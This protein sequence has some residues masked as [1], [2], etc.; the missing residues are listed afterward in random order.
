MKCLWFCLLSFLPLIQ[1]C[2]VQGCSYL[3]FSYKMYFSNYLIEVLIC[4]LGLVLHENCSAAFSK[5]QFVEVESYS[6]SRCVIW[7]SFSRPDIWGESQ[8][9]L[10]KLEF[11]FFIKTKYESYYFL[12][13]WNDFTN[14]TRSA[15]FVWM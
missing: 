2:F 3:T 9:I 12:R 15:V 5:L 14:K 8:V 7:N 10:Y 6:S 13:H 4:S 1:H 11:F